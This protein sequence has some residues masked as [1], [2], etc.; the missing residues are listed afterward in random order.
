[1]ATTRTE[2]RNAH[3][4]QERLQVQVGKPIIAELK[5]GLP[6][7]RKTNEGLVEYTRYKEVMYKK[8]WELG[9]GTSTDDGSQSVTN[10]VLDIWTGNSYISQVGTITSGTWNGDIISVTSGGTGL[11]SIDTLLNSSTTQDDVGLSN[12]ENT[13]LSTWPGT[14]NITTLGTIT[15]GSFAGPVGIGNT[16]IGTTARLS[17]RGTT[18]DATGECIEVRSSDT[19]ELFFIRNDGAF[20]TGSEAVSPYNNTTVNAANCFINTD[21]TLLRYGSSRKYKR[22]INNAEHGLAEV[23]NLRPVTFQGKNKIDK[24]RIFGGLIAE[25]VNDLGLSEFVEY[26]A[27]D[28][29][30]GLAYGAMVSLLI[31]A[32]QEL[33]EI[34]NLKTA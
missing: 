19:T 4:K 34:N 14:S 25:E 24:D 13:A 7:L 22:N 10:A 5:E 29:P 1:M 26:G 12:V 27:D 21:G 8:I 15:T 3:K 20:R 31:K 17:I 23:L 18:T 9:T 6:V 28:T 33:I 2:R 30:E 16:G 11:S 32:V